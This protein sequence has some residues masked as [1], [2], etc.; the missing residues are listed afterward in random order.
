MLVRALVVGLG[1]VIA[2]SISCSDGNIVTEPAPFDLDCLNPSSYGQ[3]VGDAPSGFEQCNDGFIH[4][5]EAVTC[6]R[7]LENRCS[8][9]EDCTQGG[10]G[11]CIDDPGLG[12]A[13]AYG[14]ETDADC[15]SG[16]ICM[17][18]DL[19]ESNEPQCVPAG[20]A[21]DADC[22]GGL[23]GVERVFGCGGTTYDIACL[24]RDAECRSDCGEVRCGRGDIREP[25]CNAALDGWVCNDPCGELANCG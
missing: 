2:T 10:M 8:T 13:C 4:R 11:R 5:L 16:Q 12:N 1:L 14:C 17:C 3:V 19:L 20:C 7:R 21:S 15:G 24:T 25:L 23:C 6:A 22:D 18:A 9:D